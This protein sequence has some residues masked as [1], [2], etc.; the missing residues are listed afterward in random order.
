M[1][2][3]ARRFP[4]RN[5]DSDR[6]TLDRG[7]KRRQRGDHNRISYAACCRSNI[8][9]LS[10]LR[11]ITAGALGASGQRAFILHLSPPLTVAVGKETDHS[12]D[13]LA[14][15]QVIATVIAAWHS[16]DNA[17]YRSA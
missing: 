4:C 11:P 5:K 10:I 14:L 13:L 7:Q 3:R 16:H 1:R 9:R 8:G 12:T 6:R 17:E 2:Q 15:N